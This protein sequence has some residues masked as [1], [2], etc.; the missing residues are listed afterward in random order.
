[1]PRLRTSVS[2]LT[3][4]QAGRPIEEVARSLRLD[5]ADLVKLASN[6]SPQPPFPEVVEAITAAASEINR[7]PDNDCY[8]PTRALAPL[9]G[10]GE[11]H[12]LFGGGSS[13]LLRTI[14]LAVGGPGT[15]A[16]YPW[17]SFII[18]R[19]APLLAGGDTVE[20]PL[21]GELR[22]DLG[23]MLDAIR[24]DTTVVFLCNP[25]NPTGTYLAHSD[26]TSFIA[27]VPPETLVVVDEAYFEY[28]T[29]P[30]Y[31]T[32]IPEAIARSNVVVLRTFSKIYGLA[33]LRVGYAVG[34]P[35]TLAGLR[36][37]Q[38]PFTV[39]SLAQ[40]AAV[41]ALKHPDRVAERCRLN[42]D[43]RS[44]IEKELAARGVEYAA[45]Q[46]NFVYVRPTVGPSTAEL[47]KRGV[48]VR[49]MSDGFIRVTIGLPEENDRFLSALDEV[50]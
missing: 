19:V 7:Y 15:T 34:Q 16:V 12:I 21:D 43:E 33:A 37:A 4:Y 28:V 14:A 1:M 50:S 32:A 46:T 30:D 39:S 23:A 48:I 20:V 13:D 47:L 9:L 45:S 40:V 2:A 41:E 36:R 18:Y 10:V 8:E 6:E 11:D 17:P 25:N 31:A 29:E 22:H 24:S 38:G 3:P 42:R 49:E 26:V 5:P 44:R 35:E 27:S